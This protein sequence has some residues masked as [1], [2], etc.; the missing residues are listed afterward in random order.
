MRTLQRP[1]LIGFT[2][3]I[4]MQ[5]KTFANEGITFYLE[6]E[7]GRPDKHSIRFV[8]PTLGLTEK[9]IFRRLIVDVYFEKI[10]TEY[11]V[12]FLAADGTEVIIPGRTNNEK[13][14][15][16]SSVRYLQWIGLMGPILM[17]ML[18]D[19]ICEDIN[20]PKQYEAEVLEIATALTQLTQSLDV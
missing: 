15:T 12:Q 3:E 1:V 5:N 17:P 2:L 11:A 18:S 20:L 14:Y 9:Y 4:N 19:N 6:Y 10:T 16:T 7:E 13:K 8:N